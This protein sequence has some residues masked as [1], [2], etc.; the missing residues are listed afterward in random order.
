[1]EAL[2]FGFWEFFSVESVL[3]SDGEMNSY[4]TL[5]EIDVREGSFG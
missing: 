4:F 2:N 1:M 5:V 3:L